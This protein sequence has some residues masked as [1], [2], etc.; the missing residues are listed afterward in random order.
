MNPEAFGRIVGYV[1]VIG[2]LVWCLSWCRR[3]SDK[4]SPFGPGEPYG[5]GGWLGLFLVSSY[6]LAPLFLVSKTLIVF[7]DAEQAN[8]ILATVPG[9]LPYKIFS[10]VLVAVSIAVQIWVA[11]RLHTRFEASSVHYAKLLS[12]L[13]PFIVYGL[14]VAAAWVTL[15]VN[16]TGAEIGETIRTFVFGMLWLAYFQVSRRV[17]NT[18]LRP[19]PEPAAA[20]PAS[21]GLRRRDPEFLSGDDLLAPVPQPPASTDPR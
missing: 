13:S 9:Y 4:R 18:Y 12:G 5:T 7:S 21:G 11:R 15:R 10:W 19:M 14:D 3:D 8:P 6:V 20:A 16:A 1:L 2:L 17:R